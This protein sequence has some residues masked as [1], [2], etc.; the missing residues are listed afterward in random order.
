MS[1]TLAAEKEAIIAAL[2]LRNNE[3]FDAELDKLDRWGED[4]RVSLKV[5]LGELE[6][7][8][9]VIKRNARL[10]PNLPLKLKMERERRTLESDRETAW[11]E[12]DEAARDIEK[13]KD[14]LIDDVE[15]KLSQ[16]FNQKNLFTISWKLT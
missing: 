3:F 9:K 16:H 7:S 8:I 13:R 6:D 15:K 5:K 12:Y 2:N 11:K 14:A 10:A 1:Q 4:R